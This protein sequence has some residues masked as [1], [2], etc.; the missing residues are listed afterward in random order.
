MTSVARETEVRVRRSIGKMAGSLHGDVICA[1]HRRAGHRIISCAAG[2]N[3]LPFACEVFSELSSARI[4]FGG[5]V[6][7]SA[8]SENVCMSVCEN[9]G[10]KPEQRVERG[11]EILERELGVVRRRSARVGS[12]DATHAI[13]APVHGPVI[14]G[15]AQRLRRH[16]SFVRM[17]LRHVAG[18]IDRSGGALFELH[19]DRRGDDVAVRIS[20]IPNQ[21][22]VVAEHVAAGACRFA[23]RGRDRRVVQKASAVRDLGDFLGRQ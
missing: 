4:G 2:E 21:V 16:R 12:E 17:Q 10:S 15:A 8:K 22:I 3:A 23:V 7:A 9:V 13:A 5:I 19:V 18:A 1:R 11:D 14:H 6:I 20:Q